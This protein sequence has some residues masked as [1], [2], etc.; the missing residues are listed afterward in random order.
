M[1]YVFV[2]ICIGFGYNEILN[3]ILPRKFVS[4]RAGT[5]GGGS[6]FSSR[7]LETQ[8]GESLQEKV[9]MPKKTAD[10]GLKAVE[11]LAVSAIGLLLRILVDRQCIEV[12]LLAVI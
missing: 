8:S 10:V 9:F 2:C 4:L 3:Y 6:F 5:D 12:L 11:F 1:F 7:H